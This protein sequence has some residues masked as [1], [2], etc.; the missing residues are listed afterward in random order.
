MFRSYLSI[1]LIFFSGVLSHDSSTKLRCDRLSDNFKCRLS[2]ITPYRYI[3]NHNDSE[4]KFKDC[5]EKKIWLIIRHGTR[6]PG[7]HVLKALGELERIREAVINKCDSESCDLTNKE[8]KRL[9]DWKSDFADEEDMI[10]TEEGE[11]EMIGLGER[12]QARFPR[13]MP[14]K[15]DNRTFKFKF[16]QKQRTEESAKSFAIGLFGKKGSKNV[17]YP[18]AEMKDPILRFYKACDRWQEQVKKN[19]KSYEETNKF[20]ESDIILKMLE[21]MSNRLG[22]NISFDNARIMK[23][24]C[25]FETAWSEKNESPWCDLFT[26]EEFKVIEFSQDLKYYW[27]D[28]YGFPLTYQQA[29]IAVKDMFES[30]EL[31][32]GPMTTAYFSHSGTLLKILTLLGISKDDKPIM[33][34]QFPFDDRLW[35]TSYIDAFATNIAFIL[36]NCKSTGRSI[37]VM[38]QERIINLPGCPENIPCP[39]AIM[40]DKYPDNDD[41]CHFQEMCNT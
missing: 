11:N 22:T 8:L 33:H 5:E 29:C 20:K 15:F 3:A 18:P 9:R 37:L 17:W 40:K 13:L 25:A 23:D 34:D 26:K 7:K 28:G 32:D 6:R 2:S 14:D 35:R 4:I 31:D 36:F 41:E 24:L 16:T 21:S 39:L 30:I 19:P 12:F 10:L 27:I 1:L 38:H